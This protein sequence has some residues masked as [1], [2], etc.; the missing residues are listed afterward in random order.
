M[1]EK[2]RQAWEALRRWMIDTGATSTAVDAIDALLDD[3][4]PEDDPQ[5]TN[6]PPSMTEVKTYC[7]TWR[8]SAGSTMIEY[9]LR[10][11]LPD[12]YVDYH[13]YKALEA[14]N[15]R[16]RDALGAIRND[17]NSYPDVLARFNMHRKSTEALT[18]REGGDNERE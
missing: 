10:D 8:A 16:L 12:L 6:A 18:Q 1:T 9:A 11:S 15:A 13:E 5:S 4:S 14:E 2:Q 17:F 3:E 7:P